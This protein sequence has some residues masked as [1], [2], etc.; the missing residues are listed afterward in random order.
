MSMTDEIIS[1]NPDEIGDFWAKVIYPYTAP[2]VEANAR[3]QPDPI[4]SAVRVTFALKEYL[5]TAAHVIEGHLQGSGKER[6]KGAPYSYIPEQVD[7]E[8]EVVTVADP[9]DLAIIRLPRA[10]RPGL[11]LPQ[12]LALEVKA[13]EPCLFVGFQARPK[14]WEINS[15]SVTIR[16]RPLSYMGTVQ[17]PTMERFS[18]G[19]NDKRLYRGG[20]RQ[21][22][23]GKPNG[24]SG[25]GVFVLRQDSPRLAGIVI[26][27]HKRASEIIATS[28]LAL[29]WMFETN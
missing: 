14:S 13:G 18:I 20:E 19:F 10:S 26:E 23:V 24:I 1:T 25:A 29:R 21:N 9:I 27:Y 12:H 17:K 16:P 5:V 3:L 28:S 22:P 6:S 15:S 8:G 7:I 2:I 11:L 4:G